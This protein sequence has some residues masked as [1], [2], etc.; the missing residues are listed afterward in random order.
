MGEVCK[1]ALAA[2]VNRQTGGLPNVLA[3]QW[4]HLIDGSNNKESK[5][6]DADHFP[7]DVRG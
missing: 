7:A 5:N 4:E 6:D 1:A 2:D 3:Q